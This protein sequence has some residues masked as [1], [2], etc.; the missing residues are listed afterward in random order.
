MS[1]RDSSKIIITEP[2]AGKKYTIL[3]G[4]R[5]TGPLHMGHYV[6]SL[7]SRVK[8]QE[9][10]T[11]YVLI[12]DMQALTD[13]AN[14]P[15][16]VRD[17]VLEVM[18]DYLAVGIDPTKSTIY[19]QSAIPE[20][21]ELTMYLLNLVNVGRLS[22]NPT[23]KQ[24][25]K[26]KG[27]GEE[28]PAGFWIYPVNQ[29]ADITQFRADLVPVGH[30]QIPMIELSNDLA[31]GFNRIY[32][33]EVFVESSALVPATGL[34]PGTDGQAKMGKSLGNAIY[35][36]DPQ[37]IVTKKVKGMF[38]DP[39]HLRVED[40]GKVEGNTVFTY[41]DA[42]DPDHEKVAEMKA[43]Y[44]R[45]GLADGI[46]KQRLI[47]VLDAFLTPIR[48][49]RAEFAADKGEVLALLKRGTEQAR[50]VAAGTLAK[51]RQAIGIVEL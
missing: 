7:S 11:Q 13:N 43:H 46:V 6:G 20:T 36:S 21:A 48:A 37:D 5:P 49:R 45:G 25:I 3:T 44:T 51:V 29:A 19:L 22:R 32:K 17:N 26:A 50:A 24:E 27:F 38:T 31:R 28:V 8:F 15:T 47:E 4:D 30:D 18:L 35:L 34:L 10:Y 23:V 42:F 14:N 12:A 33:T 2:E 1:E 9:H 16:K 41:L 40:P 39:R